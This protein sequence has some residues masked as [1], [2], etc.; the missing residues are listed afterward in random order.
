M[1][2]YLYTNN[3][4]EAGTNVTK[5]NGTAQ[6]YALADRFA[7]YS[8]IAFARKRFQSYVELYQSR[9]DAVDGALFEVID[10]VF[11]TTP[12]K[13]LGLRAILLLEYAVSRDTK[14]SDHM[15][16]ENMDTATGCAAFWEKMR[17]AAEAAGTIRG[18]KCNDCATVLG[19]SANGWSM[20]PY[21]CPKLNCGNSK[22]AYDWLRNCK[23]SDSPISVAS[24]VSDKIVKERAM[25]IWSW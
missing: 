11:R 15:D 24:D 3:L 4:K 19:L 16:Q 23:V 7:I 17:Q 22:T 21:N 8:L 25:R 5:L 13:N 18:V 10:V 2:E 20:D 9:N 14:T 1:L 12:P 6:L